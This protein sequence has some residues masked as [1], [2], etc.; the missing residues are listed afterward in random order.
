MRDVERTLKVLT[1]F[2]TKQGIVT[3]VIGV[4]PQFMGQEFKV[5]LVLSLGVTFYSR[6]EDR[7]A[8]LQEIA[9]ILDLDIE[10]FELIVT[11]CQRIFIDE[12]R[13]ENTI[14]KNKAL[15]E[16]VFNMIICIELRIPLFLVGK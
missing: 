6:L 1:W 10:A 12:M 3:R 14:A 9:P 11:T 16:N 13:L 7:Y 2:L 8:Y 4:L 15:M 5:N